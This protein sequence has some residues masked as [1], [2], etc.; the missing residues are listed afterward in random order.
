MERRNWTRDELI[1]AFNL[2]CKTPFGRIHYRNSD[3]IALA[4]VLGRTPSALSW[5]LANFARFDPALKERDI[6]GATHGGKLEGEVWNE[7][8]ENWEDLAF[9]SERLRLEMSG[10]DLNFEPTETFPAGKTRD[11]LI[12]ARVN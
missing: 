3:I 5:K 1:V 4:R 2:Y 8:S 10:S 11:A 9:E 7:F 12:R 6:A